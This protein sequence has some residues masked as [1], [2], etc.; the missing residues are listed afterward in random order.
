LGEDLDPSPAN[1]RLAGHACHVLTTAVDMQDAAGRIQATHQRIDAV[2][3][4]GQRIWR[5]K[6]RC[7]WSHAAT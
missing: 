5:E 4:A 1:G 3:Q 6:G 2:E 7:R